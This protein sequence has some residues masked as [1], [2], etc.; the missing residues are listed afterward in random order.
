MYRTS[1]SQAAFAMLCLAGAAVPL[2][3]AAQADARHISVEK[4]AEEPYALV[5]DGQR[6]TFVGARTPDDHE[7]DALRKQY[8]GTFV[9]FRQAGKTYVV[10]D[11]A[12]VAQVAA[13]WSRTD[14]L[15]LDMKKYQGPMREKGAAMEALSKKMVAAVRDGGAVEATRKQMDELGQSMDA[16]GKQMN[17]LGKQI[18]RESRQA[19]AVTRAV[20]REALRKGTAQAV[21]TP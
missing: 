19:D 8:P 1:F 10:R 13:A 5:R 6:P 9:W 17:A 3:A 4:S 11:P 12:T 20:L 7:V 21:L 16:L 14:Q 18:E 15:G 2:H